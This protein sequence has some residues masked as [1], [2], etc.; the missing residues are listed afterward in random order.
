[1]T[2]WGGLS[3][4]FSKLSRRTGRVLSHHVYQV[5]YKG[6]KTVNNQTRRHWIMEITGLGAEPSS[7]R[8]HALYSYFSDAQQGAALCCLTLFIRKMRILKTQQSGCSED[9][10]SSAKCPL[11]N[12]TTQETESTS[13]SGQPDLQSEFQGTQNLMSFILQE[14]TFLA[15]QFS[16]SQ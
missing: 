2:L 16:W 10:I 9:Q 3:G 14:D 15:W 5:R 8:T 1:M 11:I 12:P 7:V 13:T 6:W 4:R